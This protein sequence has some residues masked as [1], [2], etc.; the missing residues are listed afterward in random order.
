MMLEV[1]VLKAA[2][3]G[4]IRGGG[5]MAALRAF[6]SLLGAVFSGKIVKKPMEAL[7]E[8]VSSRTQP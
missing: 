7:K 4:A 3:E 1:S 8:L 2:A 5:S 6:F